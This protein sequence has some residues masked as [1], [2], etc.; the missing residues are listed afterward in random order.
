MQRRIID[1]E[2]Y[3]VEEGDRLT[4]GT[5]TAVITY[6]PD[7]G[8]DVGDTHIITTTGTLI[9]PADCAISVEREEA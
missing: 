2:A 7:P 3:L 1:T 6:D 5:V 9:L 8:D 4:T